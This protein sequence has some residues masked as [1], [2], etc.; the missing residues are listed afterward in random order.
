MNKNVLFGLSG[1]VFVWSLAAAARPVAAAAQP[2]NG[3]TIPDN[4]A[5][6][7]NP[8]A[9]DQK[10][11]EVGKTLFKKR[12]EKC[13]GPAGKGDGPDA[14]PDVQDDMDLTVARR[15]SKNP[16]GIVF[17]KMWN[18]RA[19]PKMPAVKDEL[20]KEQVWQIVSYVQT[21]RQK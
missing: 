12:C 5:D 11:V 6:E 8:L 16:D 4:A 14:D 15:A 18:G 1:L 19:K 21:L 2:P 7:K 9:S 10:A 20:T 17:Y 13:H 3:W